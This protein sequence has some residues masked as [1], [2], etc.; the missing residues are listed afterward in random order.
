[1]TLNNPAMAF[2]KNLKLP[3]RMLAMSRSENPLHFRMPY[4]L[5]LSLTNECDCKCKNCHIWK[6][7]GGC[8][9]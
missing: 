4:K 7:P 1:M 2:L 8:C 9:K 6:K 5:A 3:G